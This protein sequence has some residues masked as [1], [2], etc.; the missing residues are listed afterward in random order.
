MISTDEEIRVCLECSD[1]LKGRK[2]Q[3]FCSDYCRNSYHNKAN[4]VS[5]SMIRNINNIL[6]KNRRVLSALNP[7]G[8]ATVSATDLYEAGFNFHYYTNCF[9]TKKGT[10]YYFCYDQGYAK[11]DGESFVLVEKQDYVK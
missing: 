11:I 8:K 5:N 9:S 6:R 10:E 7:H 1:A 4:E 2:D 3:R